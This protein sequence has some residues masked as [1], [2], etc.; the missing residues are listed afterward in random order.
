MISPR[1]RPSA[2]LFFS[3]LLREVH[4]Y[5]RGS[6]AQVLSLAVAAVH[7]VC[8]L[9]FFEVR[10]NKKHIL[11]NTQR[12]QHEEGRKAVPFVRCTQP[13]PP[14]V[15][16]APTFPLRSGSCGSLSV[17]AVFVL[18][19]CR[20]RCNNAKATVLLLLLP[21]LLLVCTPSLLLPSSARPSHAV[22]VAVVASTQ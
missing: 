8:F 17:T 14:G 2:Q 16:Q 15:L 1:N 20:L 3:S 5:L 12:V 21:L 9:L 4:V 18:S 22:V 11:P 13:R 6:R 7:A 19:A 10:P